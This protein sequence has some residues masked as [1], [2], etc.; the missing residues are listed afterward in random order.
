MERDIP[1]IA[2]LRRHWEA[3][4]Q[5]ASP[6]RATL[7][8][9]AIKALLPQ[10]MLVEFEHDPFRVRYRVTGSGIDEAT[11][12]NLTGRYLDEFRVEPFE[13]GV[14]ELLR[15]YEEVADSGKSFIG[16]YQWKQPWAVQLKVPYGIFPLAVHGVV[17]QAIAIERSYGPVLGHRT[18]TWKDYVDIHK[19]GGPSQLDLLNY[20]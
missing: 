9:E 18:K 3:L 8:L 19:A 20:L 7:D 15:Q 6:E 5:G 10:V 2:E 11:G 16:T 17:K 14:R 1:E 4:G 12:Y 13:D